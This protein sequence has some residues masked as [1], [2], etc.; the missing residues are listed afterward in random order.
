M[1]KICQAGQICFHNTSL[2]DSN[3]GRF[4]SRISK[5]VSVPE[6]AGEVREEY[7]SGKFPVRP[8]FPHTPWLTG[9]PLPSAFESDKLNRH[10]NSDV[11]SQCRSRCCSHTPSTPACIATATYHSTMS[12]SKAALL[13]GGITHAR[14]EWEECGS[15]L[16]LKV[17]CLRLVAR[18]IETDSRA[19]IPRRLT[20]RLPVKVPQWRLRQCLRDLPKQ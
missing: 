19:G 20:R 7:R 3:P 6:A 10:V 15:L 5:P 17:D 4:A 18:R 8:T 11:K 16:S 13:I 12:S 14:K 2:V 9:I 1:A